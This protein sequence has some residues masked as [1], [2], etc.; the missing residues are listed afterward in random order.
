MIVVAPSLCASAAAP[1]QLVRHPLSKTRLAVAAQSK[2]NTQ[3]TEKE[4]T[5]YEAQ[6]VA[7]ANSD[8]TH[9]KAELEKQ[10]P[11]VKVIDTIYSNASKTYLT[12]LSSIHKELADTLMVKFTQPIVDFF[13]LQASHY[14][15]SYKYK[16]DDKSLENGVGLLNQA[17]GYLRTIT[18]NSHAAEL[19]DKEL[20]KAKELIKQIHAAVHKQFL[21]WSYNVNTQTQY[22][23]WQSFTQFWHSNLVLLKSY[24][25]LTFEVPDYGAIAKTIVDQISNQTT[26]DQKATQER[27]TCNDSRNTVHTAVALP[28]DELYDVLKQRIIRDTFDQQMSNQTVLYFCAFK[29][30]ATGRLL[31]LF[32]EEQLK[33]H[34]DLIELYKSTLAFFEFRDNNPLCISLLKLSVQKIMDRISRIEFIDSSQNQPSVTRYL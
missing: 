8:L 4:K 28:L 25:L 31:D 29:L 2:D 24:K 5:E 19:L 9:L 21:L 3:L 30:R 17:F 27:V 23:F 14:F 11:C 33:E 6:L 16:V 18:P 26:V 12:H 1:K 20:T 10:I 22:E 15:K 13:I 34:A 7:M 32:S